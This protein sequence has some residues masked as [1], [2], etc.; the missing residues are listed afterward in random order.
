MDI[1]LKVATRELESG[2]EMSTYN[3]LCYKFKTA[4]DFKFTH[5]YEVYDD[6]SESPDYRLGHLKEGKFVCVETGYGDSIPDDK[7]SC[8]GVYIEINLN[9]GVKIG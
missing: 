1:V 4:N 5:L 3:H 7:F 8:G 2:K 6:V 9:R